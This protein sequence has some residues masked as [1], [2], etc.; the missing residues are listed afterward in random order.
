[1]RF[2]VSTPD[3]RPAVIFDHVMDAAV[4]CISVQ[5]NT[6]AES[7]VRI[8]DSEQVLLTAA[9]VLTPSSAFLQLEGEANKGIIVEGGDLSNA[10]SAVIFKNGASEKSINLRNV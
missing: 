6:V 7:V 2:Q 9:R 4:D 1:V 5:G 10:T 3:L 8:I